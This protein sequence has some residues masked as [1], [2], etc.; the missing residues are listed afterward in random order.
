MFGSSNKYGCQ[1][2][3]YS[4][5]QL[6]KNIYILF[7]SFWLCWV[8]AAEPGLSLVAGSGGYFSLWCSGFSLLRL[9]LLWSV[10]SR[11]SGFS[12][13]G[14]RQSQLAGSRVWA[15][16][17]CIWAQSL[18]G[19]WNLPGP[20]IEPLTPTLA[21]QLFPAVPGKSCLIALFRFMSCDHFY[22]LRVCK[23]IQPVLPKG[24]QS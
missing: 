12:S 14:L 7:V 2:G 16:Q 20:G 22:D 18:H 17:V 11:C 13:C 24:N 23:E 5:M 4:F 6:I 3:K 9:L 21:G 1:K 10:G 15:Q 19:V 8:F